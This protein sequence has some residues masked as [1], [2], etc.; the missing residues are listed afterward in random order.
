MLCVYR[1]ALPWNHLG[2]SVRGLAEQLF[3]LRHEGRNFVVFRQVGNWF[4]EKA[5]FW[6]RR[7]RTVSA[8]EI[9]R[10]RAE[11]LIVGASSY[12]VRR[13]FEQP[14]GW[15][16]R[17]WEQLTRL[18]EQPLRRR[19]GWSKDVG[20]TCRPGFEESWRAWW[21][22]R[23]FCAFPK[24]GS[25]RVGGLRGGHRLEEAARWCWS[26]GAAAAA[27]KEAS[28]V[29]LGRLEE[30]RLGRRLEQARGKRT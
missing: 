4:S 22:T 7:C 20:R 19:R 14:L 17:S 24:Q 29:G 2:L 27:G 8:K 12:R 10:R 28:S 11:Q 26:K 9:R 15:G 13:G 3:P 1:R 6:A 21:S 5:L 16:S 18:F 25:R 30:V 23:F